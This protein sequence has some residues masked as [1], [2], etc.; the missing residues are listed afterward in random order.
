[1]CHAWLNGFRGYGERCKVSTKLAKV[2]A[3]DSRDLDAR[4]QM[5]LGEPSWAE[6]SQSPSFCNTAHFSHSE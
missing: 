1:M 5:H 6:N 3:R 2:I 4:L